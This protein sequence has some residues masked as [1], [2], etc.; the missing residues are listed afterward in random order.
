MLIMAGVAGFG[1]A[2]R[3]VKGRCLDRLATPLYAFFTRG[4]Y[5]NLKRRICQPFL[6]IF[7]QL[8]ESL[9]EY[10]GVVAR[11]EAFA[12]HL[13]GRE[14][15][16]A[17]FIEGL[18]DLRRKSFSVIVDGYFVERVF[19]YRHFLDGER[20]KRSVGGIVVGFRERAFFDVCQK[21]DGDYTGARVAVGL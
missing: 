20:E 1:P 14:S 12:N 7:L 21:R 19:A 5:Y 9:A 17:V 15:E 6:F 2:D 3:G 16:N 8:V 13:V 18:F 4:Y 10:R 11:E